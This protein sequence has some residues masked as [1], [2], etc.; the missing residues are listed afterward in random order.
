M[1]ALLAAAF[2]QQ[3]TPIDLTHSPA[4]SIR[5]PFSA[6]GAIRELPGG[7]AIVVDPRERAVVLVDFGGGPT[8]RIGRQGEGPGEYRYPR[9]VVAGTGTTS[10]IF[11]PPL[12]R[13]NGVGVDGK[14]AGSWPAP[15]DAVPGGVQVLRGSDR[16]GRLY[17]EG[18]EYDPA[19]GGFSR[20]VPIASWL[21][22][23]T[24][25]DVIA[26]IST[27]GRVVIQRPGGASSMARSISPYPHIDA[28]A[29]LPDG[30]IA[31]VRVD[32]YRI[33]IVDHDGTAHTGQPLAYSPIPITAAERAAFR[34]AASGQRVGASMRGGGTGGPSMP[35]F[36]WHDEDF[37][38]TMPPF[39]HDRVL[40][41]PDG[42]IWVGRSQ[43]LSASAV[44]YD[45]FDA[46]G[47]V[48]AIATLKPHSTII[49][50]GVRAIYVARQDPAD[51]MLYLEKYAR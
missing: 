16:E 26:R 27:G 44:R 32:P 31:I 5:E 42:Q 33:D 1:L 12:S 21:P 37:P 49:G 36:D 4:A 10:W 40:A 22:G 47:R 51:D 14:A 3:P 30:R 6:L 34:E 17:F 18:N 46:T 23:A 35:G 25:A 7:R 28:W 39:I 11:D 15:A 20:T 9:T 48:V 50:F 43:P 45:V 19:T 13:V 41:S 38:T 8:Q 24:K 2:L 29:P